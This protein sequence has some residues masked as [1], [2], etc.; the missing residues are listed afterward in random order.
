MRWKVRELYSK[1]MSVKEIART[2][3]LTYHQVYHL[4]HYDPKRT[5]KDWKEEYLQKLKLHGLDRK[6]KKLLTYRE[7]RK[8]REVYLKFSEIQER[9]YGDFLMH[10]IENLSRSRWYE[11]L[12]FFVS[13]EMGTSWEEVRAKRKR[14]VLSKGSILREEGVMEIDATGWEFGGKNYSIMLSLDVFS[15]F[16]LSYMVVENKEKNAK[17]Y[18]KAFDRF[19][20]AKFL[21]DTFI[22]YGVPRIIKSDNERVIKNEFVIS[23]L[24][25]LGVKHVRTTP[26]EPQQKLIENVIGKLKSYMVGIKTGSVEE[27]LDYAVSRWNKSV[28]RFKHLDEPVIPVEVFKEYEKVD[29]DLI[30][31]AFAVRVTRK[32]R[33]NHISVGNVKYE[34]V[35]P[36]ELEVKALIHLDDNT[37]AELYDADTGEYLGVAYKVS[38]SLGDTVPEESQKKRKV[39]RIERRRRRYEEEISRLEEEKRQVLEEEERE[40][41]GR[42]SVLELAEKLKEEELW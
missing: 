12:R 6:L 31:Q 16:V 34:F 18:N 38:R 36:G 19:D 32:L 40:R 27:L 42:E 29:Q 39:R 10:G 11:F 33:D 2:L 22:A 8:G 24:E 30:T 15:G 4:L 37:K 14:K 26:G 9:L 5:E 13:A 21:Q 17:H 3:G 35:Y 20:V 25:R 41:E 1:G 7:E 28:H 23:A